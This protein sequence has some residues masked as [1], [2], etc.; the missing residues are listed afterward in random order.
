MASVT[1]S[2]DQRHV[3][4][5]KAINKIVRIPELNV[6]NLEVLIEARGNRVA[7]SRAI[8]CPCTLNSETDQPS[9]D[10]PRC[11]GLGWFYFGPTNYAVPVYA[12][13][14]TPLQQSI[15]DRDACLIRGLIYSLR[16]ND[17]P[18]SEL[19]PW[20]LGSLAVS[21]RHENVIGYYDRITVL[22]SI[23]PYDEVVVAPEPQTEFALRYPAVE[24]NAMFSETTRY[25]PG[26]DFVVTSEGC[27]SWQSA[28]YPAGARLTVH[29]YFH[30]QY[31][32]TSRPRVIRATT[33]YRKD[34]N[35]EPDRVTGPFHV[36]LPLQA[37]LQLEFLREDSRTS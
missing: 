18:Y 10:C 1:T 14:L 11:Q 7:W 34:S 5:D 9:F 8:R 20:Q 6:D 24:V 19:G 30:P 26:T 16:A 22:D 27:I 4:G 29:Y 28:H 15:V 13:E 36:A 21:V 32:V 37:E 31:L 33:K 35:C 25:V 3:F 17:M 2:S 23:M 12:G